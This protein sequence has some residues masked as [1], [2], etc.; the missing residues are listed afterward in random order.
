MVYFVRTGRSGGREK[1]T[2]APP[3]REVVE[4]RKDRVFANNI[5]AYAC[6]K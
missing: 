5:A 2:L 1:E 4:R 3:R 6:R